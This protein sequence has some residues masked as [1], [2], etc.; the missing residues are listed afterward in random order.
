M[1]RKL[2]LLAALL[3]CTAS[4]LAEPRA[5]IDLSSIDPAV[6]P[7]EDFWQFANGKWLAANADPA[8][9]APGTPSP[10]CAKPRRGNCAIVIEG[11]DPAPRRQRARASSPISMAR[12]WMRRAS[13]QPASAACATS[14]GAS[15]A[16]R[17]Q[18]GAAGVVRRSVP[19]WVRIPWDAR[20]RAGRARCHDLCRASEQGR[21][22][23]PDR[24]YYLQGRCAFPVSPGRLSRPHRQ[25]A[26]A[27]RRERRL[28]TSADGIIA[29]ETALA[30]LQW[31]RVENRDPIKTYNKTDYRR[32][33]GAD[34][35]RGL[36][37]LSSAR[38]ASARHHDLVVGQPSYFDGPRRGHRRD[39]ARDLAGISRLQPAQRLCAEYLS[40]PFVAEDFAFEQHTL[41]GVPE[42][43]P[44]WKRAVGV[45]DRPDRFRRSASS[46]SSVI[47]RRPTRRVP[48]R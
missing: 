4:S 28:E 26:D 16:L 44:R 36:A 40:A 32:P 37:V 20:Y 23:L 30:R 6:R 12:S 15:T 38:P 43:Q 24:D 33:A 47:S 9:R 2:V 11:I 10:W 17:R 48:R 7:Q 1:L 13:R 29:L 45:V 39:A 18:G 5:G 41:R 35:E 14:C 8:D 46:M 42:N 21:L 3:L 25:T 34:R 22:G 19:L 31:T 27:G